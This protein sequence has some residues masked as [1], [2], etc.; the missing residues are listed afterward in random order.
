MWHIATVMNKRKY[1]SIKE[2]VLQET[3]NG[4]NKADLC[5]KFGLKN[6]TI[7]TIWKNGTRIIGVFKQN[8]LQIKWFQKPE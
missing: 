2:K 3:E 6:S 4:K 7:Q 5:W 1:L 8:G